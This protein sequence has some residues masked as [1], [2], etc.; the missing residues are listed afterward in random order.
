MT[1][2]A[3]GWRRLDARMLLVHPLETLIRFLPALLALVVFRAGS[4]DNDRWELYAVPL[5]VA[6]GVLRWVTTRYRIA[7]GQIELRRGLFTK[8]TTTAR[9]DKVRTIDL[10]ARVYHRVLGLAKVEI[11][12]A[13]GQH[14]RLV[15]DSL[16]VDAGRRLRAELLHRVDPAVTGLPA[17]TGA[18]VAVD[19]V[20]DEAPPPVD[21]EVLVRLDPSWIRYAPLTVT[22]LASAA[23][24]VGFA[25]QGFSRFSQERSVFRDGASFVSRLA[26]WV[27]VLLLL[28]VVSLLAVGAYVLTFWGFRLT[29][30]RLGTLHTRR[31]LLTNRET[32]IDAARVRGVRLDE[33]LGLRLAGASRLKVVT[34]GLLREQG[35]SDWLCPPAP[36]G[37]VTPL[38]LRIRPD[39]AA[40]SGPL[41]PHGPAARRRRLTRAVVPAL[42]VAALL[43][44]ARLL[45][46]WHGSLLV[47]VPLLLVG[48]VALGRDRYRALGHAVTPDHLVTRHGSLDRQRVVL[49]RDGIIGWK[50]EQ[51]F[52]QRRVGVATLVA[53]TAAGAQHYDVVDLPVEM[54][55]AVLAQVSPDLVAE[56]A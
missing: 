55:Y 44:V 14:D 40:V 18:P 5:I 21:D 53:T 23:A 9:L 56:F 26:W 36:A 52:F 48:A 31:G 1:E 16:G 17:P 4:E 47:L 33:P 25:S 51:S 34:S 49:D 42:L 43:V 7:D 50:V 45:W 12:T 27:D 11:S 2:D 22:G 15:L 29:R 41:T 38:A 8:Q 54:A 35:G 3:E 46:D 30:N 39:E 20:P 28:G 13:G 32:S 24:I 37:V 6:F 10:T 19:D